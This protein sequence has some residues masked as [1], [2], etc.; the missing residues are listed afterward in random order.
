MSPNMSLSLWYHPWGLLGESVNSTAWQAGT[1][2]GSGCWAHAQGR[3]VARGHLRAICIAPESGLQAPTPSASWKARF[4]MTFFF[5]FLTSG[6]K[7]FKKCLQTSQG[8]CRLRVLMTSLI[9]IMA[10]LPV[11][12]PDS[13]STPGQV[14]FPALPD[15]CPQ[16]FS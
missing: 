9:S 12:I 3:P 5:F 13:A 10:G 7:R 4:K 11:T 1:P 2:N 14:P 8:K 15:V 6:E 16:N